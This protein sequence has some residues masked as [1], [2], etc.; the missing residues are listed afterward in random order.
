[1]RTIIRIIA[2]GL[3][4]FCAI[5]LI[6]EL[7]GT[8]RPSRKMMPQGQAVLTDAGTRPAEGAAPK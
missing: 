5:S 3:I 1:M 8:P 2:F 6:N 7:K 4:I